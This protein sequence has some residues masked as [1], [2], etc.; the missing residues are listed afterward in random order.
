MGSSVYANPDSFG[1]RPRFDSQSLASSAAYTPIIPLERLQM[2]RSGFDLERIQK[3][4]DLAV[5][6]VRGVDAV[7]FHVPMVPSGGMY[8][9]AEELAIFARFLL[10]EG[11]HERQLV[12]SKES[13]EKLTT[14]LPGRDRKATGYALGIYKLK[15]GGLTI[16]YHGGNG[17]GFESML[18]CVPEPV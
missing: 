5:G 17:Y 13:F 2:K 6:Q 7:P 16:L 12:L 1:F 10:N 3:D 14:V 9:T 8:S 18:L 4:K 15:S 11:M